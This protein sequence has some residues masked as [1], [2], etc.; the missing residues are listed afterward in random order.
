MQGYNIFRNTLH[1]YMIVIRAL[2][3]Y[4]KK[5]LSKK[6]RRIE[7]SQSTRIDEKEPSFLNN[8]EY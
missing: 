5:K 3:L 6:S 4:I 2:E 7:Q 1:R 8:M